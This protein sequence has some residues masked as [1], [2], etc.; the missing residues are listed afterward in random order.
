MPKHVVTSLSLSDQRNAWLTP[1]QPNLLLVWQRLE[2]TT[3]TRL[4]HQL[5]NKKGSKPLNIDIDWLILNSPAKANFPLLVQQA[6][7]MLY[8]VSYLKKAWTTGLVLGP[9]LACQCSPYSLILYTDKLQVS[10][11]SSEKTF[12]LV[13]EYCV[14]YKLLIIQRDG[15]IGKITDVWDFL[16]E[17]GT[18][19][20]FDGKP[21]SLQCKDRGGRGSA[22]GGTIKIAKNYKKSILL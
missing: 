3:C 16:T 7:T 10:T 11:T 5:R 21:L 12:S 6:C 9:V 4:S 13:A 19:S 2:N 1:D 22:N 8:L 18:T 20:K 14:L 15:N 17:L